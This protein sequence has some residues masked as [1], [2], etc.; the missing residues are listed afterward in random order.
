MASSEQK[1]ELYKIGEK[2]GITR[3]QTDELLTLTERLVARSVKT[4]L[5]G[6]VEF[7]GANRKLD[8]ITTLDSKKLADDELAVYKAY[9]T[10][11]TEIDSIPNADFT[12]FQEMQYTVGKQSFTL[13]MQCGVGPLNYAPEIA[14]PRTHV[15]ELMGHL[16]RLATMTAN[17]Y[18]TLVGNANKKIGDNLGQLLPDIDVGRM[19]IDEKTRVLFLDDS[20]KMGV[21]V[22]LY[23]V[24]DK[25]QPIEVVI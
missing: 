17:Y 10:L 7:I 18:M 16:D 9:R 3:K 15:K 2:Q 14:I 20:Y 13:R 4:Y 19:S 25:G 21:I 22:M 5:R 23:Y 12:G 1:E 11:L 24:N 6:L 8:K